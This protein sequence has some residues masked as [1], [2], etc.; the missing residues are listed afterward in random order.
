MQSK[1]AP[2]ILSAKREILQKEVS[3]IEPY[4]ELLHVD[5][6]DGKFVPPTTFRP[7]EIKAVKTKLP[8]DVHLMV[9]HPLKDGFIDAY[10]DAG[11]ASITIHA[12]AKDDIKTCLAY[13]KK[14][15]IKR[16]ISINPP[17]PLSKLSPYLDEVDMV[18]IMSV[19]PGWAGQSFIS[20]VLEKVSALRKL[21]PNLDIE[22]DGGISKDTIKQAA[23]AG[24]NVFVAGN[25]IF[26][27]PDRKK[28][29]ED[30]RN[31]LP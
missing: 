6:M 3:E 7:E 8:K 5:I 14:K 21:K 25:A 22:I 28:A 24:A 12:E 16:A 2:S 23:E 31:A 15:G 29:I 13:L 10:I 9:E 19:N 18:L 27:K 20:E 30:L 4:V 17:T 11:A 1:I 26:N